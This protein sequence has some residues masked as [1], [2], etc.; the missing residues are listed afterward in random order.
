MRVV[1]CVVMMV[2]CAPM[3]WGQAVTGFVGGNEYD[4]YY[5]S[6]GGDVVGWRFTVTTAL[7]ISDLGV[8]NAD[9]T[10]ALESSHQVGVWDESQ[11]LM[12][13][14]TVESS[15]TVVG[16]WIYASITPVTL[17]PGQTYT[18]GVSYASGD[19]DWYISSATSMTTDPSVTWTGSCYPAA[20]DMGFV[21]PSSDSGSYGRFGPNFLITVIPVTLMTFTTE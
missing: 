4:S 14:V 13:S 15:G 19:D 11:A 1:M 20:G 16:D 17:N 21:Y 7:N 10:G 6:V 18:I 12:A 9:Q 2:V 3:A 8:W 5:G